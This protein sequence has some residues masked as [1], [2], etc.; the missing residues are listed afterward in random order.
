MTG[1]AAALEALL[2]QLAALA[3]ASPGQEICGLAVEAGAG[4]AELWPAENAAPDPARAFQI[5]PAEVLRTLR[6]A[7]QSGRKILALY[8]SHPSGGAR[9]SVRD[10]DELTVD[11]APVLPGVELWVVGLE[12]GAATEIRAYTWADGAYAERCLRRSPFTV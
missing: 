8:H 6:R 7:D 4:G 10:L 11:G 5:A 9:L 12:E 1:S 3:E 2:G